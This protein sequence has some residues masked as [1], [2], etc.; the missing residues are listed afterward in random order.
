MIHF[1]EDEIILRQ[2]SEEKALY[3]IIRG[4]VILYFNYGQKDEYIVG[5]LSEQRCFGEFSILCGK[6]SIYTVVAYG[7]V[8]V[9]RIPENGFDDFIRNNSANAIGIMKN[10]ANTIL[11][12][13]AN[14]NLVLSELE[15][16]QEIEPEEYQDIQDITKKVRL[17]TALDSHGKSRFTTSVYTGDH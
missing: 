10:L 13:S 1:V 2:G 17:Y 11:T 12:L 6:P 8:L 16:K 4:K 9:M 3:K 15:G 14:V 5:T 7:D